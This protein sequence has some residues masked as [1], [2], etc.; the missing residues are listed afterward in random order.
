M[1][2]SDIA[3]LELL[4]RLGCQLL[5]LL[6]RQW[7]V[8]FVFQILRLASAGMIADDAVEDHDRAIFRPL[9]SRNNVMRND[10]L[11]LNADEGLV[12]AALP[13]RYRRHQRYLVA[14]F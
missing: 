3:D 13:T 9:Q 7:F 10:A 4:P 12:S 8:C 5:H 2:D 6:Q 1:D 14:V 11:A